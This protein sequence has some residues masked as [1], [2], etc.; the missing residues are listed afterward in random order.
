[1]SGDGRHGLCIGN[2]PACL[3]RATIRERAFWKDVAQVELGARLHRVPD[4][5]GPLQPSFEI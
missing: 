2:E 3:A 5:A 1:M 4:A